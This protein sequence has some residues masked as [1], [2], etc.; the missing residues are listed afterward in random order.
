MRVALEKVEGIQQVNVTLKRGVAHITFKDGNTV[1]LQQLRKVIKD[2][3]YT[4]RDAEVTVRGSVTG[5][6]KLVLAISGT[7]T[8][9]ALS[10]AKEGA[11]LAPLRTGSGR[12]LLVEVLGTVPA[13]EGKSP[14]DTLLVRSFTVVK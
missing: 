1:T 2:A 3:G 11:S 12:G 4:T 14:A 13:P 10:Q 8:S 5:T 9:L 7:H 6:Q